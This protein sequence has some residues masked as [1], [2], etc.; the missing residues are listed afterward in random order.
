[1][2]RQRT[3]QR[4][5]LDSHRQ[6]VRRADLSQQLSGPVEG[7]DCSSPSVQCGKHAVFGHHDRADIPELPGPRAATPDPTQEAPVGVEHQY[8]WNRLAQHVGPTR[9]VQ[10]S[11]CHLALD[12]PGA[13]VLAV[14]AFGDQRQA[15]GS[16]ARLQHHG[17]D[18]LLG[19]DRRGAG[20][21]P[22][23]HRDRHNKPAT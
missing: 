18:R 7:H 20:P 11:G 15:A 2:K 13:R 12:H 8:V 6:P 17:I 16:P 23:G 9:G 4:Q 14:L 22:G 19:F 21:E 1:M 10:P 5:R 3:L